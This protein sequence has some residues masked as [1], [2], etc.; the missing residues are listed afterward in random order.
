M[1]APKAG[2]SSA[3][4]LTDVWLCNPHFV[5]LFQFVWNM[6]TLSNPMHHIRSTKLLGFEKKWEK[7]TCINHFVIEKFGMP[8]LWSIEVNKYFLSAAVWRQM[9]F[10]GPNLSVLPK[11]EFSCIRLPYKEI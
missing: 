4:R 5:Y 1:F 7:S 9:I 2:Q 3:C 6:L 11:F 10:L 8:C